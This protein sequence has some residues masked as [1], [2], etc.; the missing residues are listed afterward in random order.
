MSSQKVLGILPR[1]RQ[2]KS[3]TQRRHGLS[4]RQQQISVRQLIQLV[5]HRR[6]F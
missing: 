6:D 2:Q 4:R 1:F 3:V 5:L